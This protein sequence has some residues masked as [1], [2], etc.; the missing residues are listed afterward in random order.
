M[1][2][3]RKVRLGVAPCLAA[4]ALAAGGGWA[5]PVVHGVLCL[6]VSGGSEVYVLLEAEEDAAA[7]LAYGDLLVFMPVT[8]DH[9]G[10]VSLAVYTTPRPCEAVEGQVE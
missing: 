7:S 2:R 8:T 1:P 9:P 3:L 10:T 6:P 5:M 4:L